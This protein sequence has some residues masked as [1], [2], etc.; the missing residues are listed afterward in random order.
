MTV[1]SP[2]RADPQAF[3]IIQPLRQSHKALSIGIITVAKLDDILEHG[4]RDG[5]VS[6]IMNALNWGD[7]EYH[8]HGRLRVGLDTV[9]LGAH[10]LSQSTVEYAS[11]LLK[12]LRWGTMG[13]L[14][15]ND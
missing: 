12:R 7:L 14:R 5:P 6:A 8:G 3:A 2:W 1:L 9:V 11:F 10:P 4:E 13:R 15:T